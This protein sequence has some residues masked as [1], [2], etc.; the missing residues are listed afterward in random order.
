M[1]AHSFGGVV[2]RG[3]VANEEGPIAGLRKKKLA[4]ELA[5][6]AFVIS[7]RFSTARFC[8]CGHTR[9]RREKVG[10]NPGAFLIQP[11]IKETLITPA[12][13]CGFA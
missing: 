8:Q 9:V 4:Y 11:D 6:D 13:R 1:I 2:F 12:R 5:Q 7:G 3:G 10:V